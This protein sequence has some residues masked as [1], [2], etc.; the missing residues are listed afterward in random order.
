MNVRTPA[1]IAA[2]VALSF[3]AATA[4]YAAT[5]RK[6]S[7]IIT[8]VDPAKMAIQPMHGKTAV[9]GRLA[10]GKTLVMVNGH[11]AQIADL[12]ITYD[13]K[14][15]LGLDDVWISVRADSQ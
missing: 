15:E 3:A 6:V 7:G 13:A 11:A 10:P 14:A 9:T 12:K 5:Q 2:L 4:S 8:Q 1:S